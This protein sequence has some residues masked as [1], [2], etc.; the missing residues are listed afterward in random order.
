[1]E[2]INWDRYEIVHEPTP[3]GET[4]RQYLL[5]M[6]GRD[7][8]ELIVNGV[9]LTWQEVNELGL[10]PLLTRIV[11]LSPLPPRLLLRKKSQEMQ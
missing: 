2:H 10:M 6:T 4:P 8:L 1:M 7:Y 9:D 5:R 3:E 11:Q